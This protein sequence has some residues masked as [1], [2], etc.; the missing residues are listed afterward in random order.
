[1]ITI[2]GNG[3]L[4][5]TPEL[6]H[7]KNGKAVTT[8]TI[9]SQGRTRDGQPDY[10]DLILWETQAEAA[11]EH[12]TKGQGV[13]FTGR[14]TPRGYQRNNGDAGAVL[15]VHGVTL[16]YGAKPRAQATETDERRPEA[17][18]RGRVESRQREGRG[19]SR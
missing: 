4:T 6:R 8:V 12:L 17:G 10:L 9:A 2:T 18:G 19:A 11:A 5:R 15:E 1:M 14:P 7:T 16:E 3:H 13:S